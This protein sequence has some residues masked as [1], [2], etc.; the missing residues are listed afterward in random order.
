M[1]GA[2]DIFYDHKLCKNTLKNDGACKVNASSRVLVPLAQSHCDTGK[3][4]HREGH[5]GCS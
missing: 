2:D 3:Y 4:S 5:G 1:H